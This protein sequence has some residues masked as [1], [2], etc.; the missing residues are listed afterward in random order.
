[1]SSKCVTSAASIHS[2]TLVSSLASS[3]SWSKLSPMTHLQH[4]NRSCFL[5]Q[6]SK[7]VHHFL[8]STYRNMQAVLASSTPGLRLYTCMLYGLICKTQAYNCTI[9]G[10]LQPGQPKGGCSAGTSKSCCCCCCCIHLAVGPAM[11]YMEP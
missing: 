5:K 2:P 10:A 1:M 9:C 11:A 4:T 7:M 6:A 3:R 8:C